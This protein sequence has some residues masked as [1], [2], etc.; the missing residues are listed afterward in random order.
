ML[1]TLILL[2]HLPLPYD[3]IKHNIINKH[4]KYESLQPKY[5][6]F[7]KELIQHMQYYMW[8]NKKLI[9]LDNPQQTLLHTI[10][11]FDYYKT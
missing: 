5:N 1:K 11:E 6:K 8:L 9:K 2:K 7:K 10:K 3:I 4:I